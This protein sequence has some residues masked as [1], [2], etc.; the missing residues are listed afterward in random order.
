VSGEMAVD[1]KV[2]GRLER[3]TVMELIS[4]LMEE[5]LL[6]NMLTIR[7]PTENSFGLRAQL[8]K[9]NTRTVFVMVMGYFDGLM[10]TV[11]T[12]DGK[13]EVALEGANFVQQPERSSFKI[14]Q[15]ESLIM[16]IE[17]PLGTKLERNESAKTLLK[18]KKILLKERS[19]QSVIIHNSM[20]F[21]LLLH[22]HKIK[23]L[24]IS[25]PLLSDQPS[26]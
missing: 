25:T 9:E 8:M 26:H 7:G 20:Y 5:N 10:A 16:E 13:R 24:F 21:S 6:A 14:G 17:D 4:G 19:K 1:M 18:K 15:K 12:A 11:T 2:N 23:S 22:I 3:E